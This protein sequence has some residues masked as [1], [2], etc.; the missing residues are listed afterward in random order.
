MEH[1]ADREA[2]RTSSGTTAVPPGD[3]PQRPRGRWIAR[4]A[5][6]GLAAFVL[7]AAGTL[8]HFAVRPGRLASADQSLTAMQ[9]MGPPPYLQ[10]VYENLNADT[11][12][13]RSAAT[14]RV[15]ATGIFVESYL[16]LARL[17][18]YASVL[19]PSVKHF[20]ELGGANNYAVVFVAPLRDIAQRQVL[21][22]TTSLQV[23]AVV[24]GTDQVLGLAAIS[25]TMSAAQVATLD[26]PPP[27]LFPPSSGVMPLR[28][29]IMRRNPRLHSRSGGFALTSGGLRGEQGWCDT[30]VSGGDAGAP[31]GY[32]S[33]TG[34][35]YLAG[36]ALP[37]QVRGQC[38]ILDAG[39]IDKLLLSLSTPGALSHG[40]PVAYLGVDVESTA[41]A[42]ASQGYQG[43]PQGAY[44][45]SVVSGGPAAAAGLHPGDVIIA[46]A[47]RP[48]ASQAALRPVIRSL[49]PGSVHTVTFL[50]A[51]ARH[52]V[53]VRF[54]SIPESQEAG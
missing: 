47:G 35:F 15:L 23:P 24:I 10:G 41:T 2:E 30:P 12:A 11:V 22:D 37:G 54:G 52:Q 8:T 28:L 38:S 1:G 40:P 25:A 27:S 26:S 7:V 48:V 34:E 3:R 5:A 43:Q 13:I 51:G 19:P 9:R 44:I 49:K 14:G 31:L 29:L 46:V 50:R 33:P 32:A 53:Q 21:V 16:S 39:N 17:P 4:A 42:R 36:L 6:G 20:L 45:L 18:G